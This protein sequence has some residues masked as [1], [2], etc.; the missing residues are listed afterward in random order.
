MLRAR[1]GREKLLPWSFDGRKPYPGTHGDAMR[2]EPSR[3][4]PSQVRRRIDS[5]CRGY[6]GV[7]HWRFFEKILAD[8]RM[9]DVCVLGVYCRC[10]IEYAS[11]ILRR[12]G[13]TA[14]LV[15]G[16][17]KFENAPCSERP[18]RSP[19]VTW[20]Q[21]GFGPAPS[22]EA[23]HSNLNKLV[24]FGGVTLAKGLAE[25]F[26]SGTTRRSGLLHPDTSHDREATAAT[27][28]AAVPRLRENGLIAGHEYSKRR[29]WGVRRAGRDRST[30]YDVH[31]AQ[32]GA[33]RKADYR[34]VPVRASTTGA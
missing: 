18:D 19:A 31:R 13:R 12:L 26:L 30:R 9:R 23:A 17:D 34:P 11:A 2:A 28:A 1:A 29:V 6:T 27:I 5:E 10:E 4:R 3:E 14:Y 33:A 24:Y 8:T 25:T 20:E 16:V 21:A 7:S 15:T 32:R 22:L